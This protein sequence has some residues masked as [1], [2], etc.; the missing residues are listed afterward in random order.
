MRRPSSNPGSIALG[1]IVAL[2]TL[3]AA[4]RPASAQLGAIESLA[5]RVSD[6]GFYAT[7]GTLSG[8]GPVESGAFG[9]ASYGLEVLFEVGRIERTVAA[10]LPAADSVELHW[11]GMVVEQSGR[12]ADTTFT[13][14]VEPVAEPEPVMEE[15]WTFELG[16]GYG[17]IS[18]YRASDSGVDLR[19]V[20]REL[21][22]ISLYASYAP[23][24]MYGGLRSGFMRLEGLQLYL[25]DDAAPIAGAADSFLAGFLV[26][27][28][29]EVLGLNFFIEGAWTVRD[30]PSVEWNSPPPPD[31]RSVDLTGWSIGTG[32]QF[33]VGG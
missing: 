13:Y 31:F 29:I 7:F 9:V 16:L 23:L 1:V 20:V 22:S 32:V 28:V 3:V 27:Q 8:G 21:P 33:S 24:G 26:G 12:R 11:V 25:D 6:L 30:F 18:G 5:G 4:P 19:G 17:E 2:S 15:I 14:A 10:P